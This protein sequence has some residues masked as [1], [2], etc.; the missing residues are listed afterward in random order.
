MPALTPARS[1]RIAMWLT[2]A[3]VALHGIFLAASLPD[4]RVSVDSGYHVSLG[5][6]YAEHGSAWWDPINYQPRGRPNL[7]GPAMHMAIAVIGRVLGGSGDAYVLANALLG[8]AQWL[9]AVFTVWHFARREGGDWAGLLAVVLLAGSAFVAG[10]FY[11]GLPSG[12]I[13]II[14]PWA[15]DFFIKDRPVISGILIAL[16]VYTH[17]GGYLTA[18]V[19]VVIAAILLRRWKPLLLTGAVSFVLALPYTVHFLRFRDW[20]RGEHGH[21]AA[22]VSPLVLVFGAIA[23]IGLLR[24]PRRNAFLLAWTLAPIAWL[25]QDYTRF[26]VQAMLAAS[27]IAAVLLAGLLEQMRPRWRYAAVAALLIV[28]TLYPLTVPSLA[29]EISW[30]LGARYPRALDWSEAKALA[31]VIERNHLNNL[32]VDAWDHSYAPSIAVYTNVRLQRGHWVEVQKPRED[33]ARDLLTTQ[34]LFIVPIPANDPHLL[35][36]ARRGWLRVWGGTARNAIV[37]TGPI[38]PSIAEETAIDA[39]SSS[40]SAAWLA[41]NARPN[42]IDPTLLLSSQRLAEHRAKM[43][44]QR[45]HAGLVALNCIAY[46]YAVEPTQPKLGRGV[47]DAFDN[48]AVLAGFL[49]DEDT[50]DFIDDKRH[51]NL[52]KNLAVWSQYVLDLE[53]Q[54][55][56]TQRLDDISDKVFREF[57][58]AA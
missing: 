11:I 55:M 25:F 12:W 36:L 10:S 22:Y 53:S 58:W 19:G 54:P 45:R 35:D 14:A 27:A 33:P 23:L 31:G 50:L 43:L 26:L 42:H 47:R 16:G 48:W 5:R 57:F 8:F 17:L 41:A 20:Y 38:R 40:E 44:E 13:F 52:R 18:P 24:H 46:G 32:L 30:A 39:R 9:C 29:A 6:W 49:G 3:I 1:S 4:Y 34:K 56:P 21:V 15:I 37:T 51:E 7:Q 28:A 2:L